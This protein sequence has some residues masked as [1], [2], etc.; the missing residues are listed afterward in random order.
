MGEV[1][2]TD[3]GMVFVEKSVTSQQKRSSRPSWDQKCHCWSTIYNYCLISW[4][5]L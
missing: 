4:A 5:R 3:W 1:E 2:Q